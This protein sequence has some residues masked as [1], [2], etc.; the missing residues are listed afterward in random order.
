MEVDFSGVPLDD[1]C[2]PTPIC[3]SSNKYRTIDGSCNN[4]RNPKFGQAFTPLQ[5]LLPNAYADGEHLFTLQLHTDTHYHPAVSFD[6]TSALI[7]F[8]MDV[9]DLKQNKSSPA[10]FPADWSR[11]HSSRP[12]PCTWIGHQTPG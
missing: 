1:F 7:R 2:P 9:K 5:R 12:S 3:N 6:N 4:L 8:K 10:K 11:D